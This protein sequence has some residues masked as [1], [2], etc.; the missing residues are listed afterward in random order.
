MTPPFQLCWLQYASLPWAGWFHSLW[1]ALLGRDLKVLA[2]PTSWGLQDDPGFTFTASCNDLSCRDS[3]AFP[4]PC[5][6]SMAFLTHGKRFH[7]PFTLASLTTLK[8][9]SYEQHH[10]IWL[11]TWDG[12][13]LFPELHFQKLSFAAFYEKHPRPFFLTN[14]GGWDLPLR[15]AVPLS[16]LCQTS[17]YLLQQ[18]LWL[19]H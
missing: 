1:A 17:L 10:Q 15:A 9:S 18:K 3:T 16:I 8:P 4:T 5:V 7:N 14:L 19:Q 12:A 13:W 11:L 2:C 6:A